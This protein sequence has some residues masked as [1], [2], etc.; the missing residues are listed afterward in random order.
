MIFTGL[1]PHGEHAMPADKIGLSQADAEKARASRFT[2]AVVL[3]STTSD[4]S[5]QELAGIVAAL[6][7]HSA[8]VIEVID[9]EFDKVTQAR[10]LHRLA[11]ERLDAVISIPVGN[12]DMAEAHRAVSRAGKTLILLDN[13]PVG[14]LCGV[15]Y[16][17]VVSADNFGLGVIGAE[18]L[19]PY[20][21]DEGVAGILTY[22]VDFFATNEREIAFRKWMGLHRPDVTLVRDKFPTL[23]EAGSAC[24]RL[25]AEND[26]LNG[27][28]VAWDVPAIDAVAAMRAGGRDLPITTVDLGNA[29]ALELT[30]GGLIKGIA[31]QRPYDLGA[32]A[33]IATLLALVGQQLP[34]WIALPGFGVTVRNVVEAYQV[35]WHAPAPA[36]LLRARKFE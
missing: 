22:G 18:L 27:L 30:E 15:D 11:N 23:G 21:P 13:A 1:G 12:A 24:N 25:L 32:A 35:V 36:S 34:P 6:G 2:I 20:I 31:A 5:R 26:D 3:H 8:A 19:S 28:F 16:A 14:L 17:G 7:S 33:G 4:W 9:C 10:E 29:V